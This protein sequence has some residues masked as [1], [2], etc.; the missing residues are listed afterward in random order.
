MRHLKKSEECIGKYATKNRAEF[1]AKSETQRT[2]KHHHAFFTHY[3]CPY[4]NIDILC[5][6]VLLDKNKT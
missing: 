4:D 1:A 3:H 5:W 2:G 6:T